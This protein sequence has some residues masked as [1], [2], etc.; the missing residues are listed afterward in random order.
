MTLPTR[1]LDDRS[2]QSIVDEA[3]KRIAASCPAWTDH[4][5]SDPGVTLV[6]LFAWMT[7]MILYRLNQVPEKHYVKF[8]E[9]MGLKL[10]EPEAAQTAVTFYLSSPQTQVI[11]IPKGTEA[12]SVRTETRPSII[13]STEEDLE[14]RPPTLV[15]LV[16][17]ELSS[18]SGSR[19][20]HRS[21]NLQHLGVAGFELPVFGREP[22][23]DSALYLGFETDLSYHVLGLDVTCQQATGL[24]IDPKNPPWHWE[25]RQE[26]EGERR[27]QPA[28]VEEDG[29]GGMNT[30][31]TIFL[32]LPKLL[33][34]TMFERRAYWIR[35]RVVEP[36]IKDTNYEASPRITNL[37]ARSWGATVW[38]SHA[39]VVQN[40]ILG[41]SDGSPGQVFQVE[42][43]PMLRRSRGEAVQVRTPGQDHW[44][45]W[46]EVPDF[47]DSGRSDRHFTCDS[48]TG[49]VRF[50]PALR[51][52][53][54]SA[55]P[56]GA[57]PPRGAQIRFSSYRYGGGVAGNVRAGTLSVV[58]TSIPY[59]DRLTNH[60][61]AIGG[62]DAETVEAAQV[63]APQ[64]L[65][66][67]GRAVTP[68][69]YQALATV[70]DSRVQRARCVQPEAAAAATGPLAGQI[71][72]LLV[73]RVHLPDGP[74]APDQLKI[75]D[76][77]RESVARY[78][79][80]YRLLSVR[81][82]IRE[83]E[84]AW[85]SVEVSLASNADADPERVRDDV[86]QRLYS[87]LNPV[88]GGPSGNG[89]PFGRDL[90][91][92]DVYACLQPVRG[93]EFIESLELYQVR[94][95][96]DRSKIDPKLDL[97]VHGLVASAE[98]RVTVR[99]HE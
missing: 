88:V 80:E 75:D 22:Q 19:A 86:E 23:I 52:P 30:S 24:G 4:N 77:L 69:D 53:D 82:D 33:P 71:Y 38:A 5:V 62:I 78:L 27:W 65:R 13:F 7:E 9:L 55:R 60:S 3:K 10:R 41:R 17:R 39:S 67:R 37:V 97:P 25:G 31:G 61:D 57:I 29:T 6:E 99:L 98:H 2:F 49:E 68:E 20:R 34:H 45:S 11:T 46:E 96:G 51:Q 42:N 32:R 28:V 54:G 90:Y 56:Y 14:I 79:E 35:C 95:S 18:S 1:T 93:I 16:T 47:G 26:A 15:A 84:Y 81:L 8:M 44:D 85:V 94:S 59:L 40:E 63:R 66:S 48:V 70:A 43:S 12:A 87:F 50:G 92:S 83:P 64:I 21:H 73:P 72:L 89:W 58:K 36:Q 74:I 91:P 76:N